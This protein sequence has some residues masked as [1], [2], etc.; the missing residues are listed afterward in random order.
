[1][2]ELPAA[3][4]LPLPAVGRTFTAARTVR[5]GDVDIDGELRLDA[6]ARYLQDVAT[7]DAVDA[8]L[9][10]A[11]GWLVRRTMIRVEQS[12]TLNEPVELTTWCTGSGRSWAERRTSIRSADGAAIDG[13]CLWVQIDVASGRPTRLDDGFHDVYGAAADARTVSS[14]LSLPKAPPPGAATGHWTFRSTDLDPFGHV[15]NAAQWALLEHRLSS[16][17]AARRGTGEIEY[18][19]PAPADRRLDL[20][21]DETGAWLVDGGSVATVVRWTP[22]GR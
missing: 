4:L 13:V 6:I 10:N 7:D 17:S 15:N 8:G 2:S 11:M 14:K 18:L 21:V 16:A 5:L 12:A 19:A 9:A 22:A 3:E 20:A 1:M